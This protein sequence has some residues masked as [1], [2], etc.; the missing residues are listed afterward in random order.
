LLDGD[1]LQLGGRLDWVRGV[2]DNFEFL[3][4]TADSLDAKE[5]PDDTLDDVPSD[6]DEDVVVLDILEAIG[7]AYKLMKENKLTTTPY[8]AIP[9]ARVS[10][11]KHST[12]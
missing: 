6:E 2:E 3:E 4:G 11:A 10:V 5:V 8:M 9:L 7:P 1:G 12:G